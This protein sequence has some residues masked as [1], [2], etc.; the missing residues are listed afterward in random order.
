M[1][2]IKKK[3]LFIYFWLH[4]VFVTVHKLFLVAASSSYSLVAVHELLISV[5][6]VLECVGMCVCVWHMA[7]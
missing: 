4:W 6:S 7:Q 5:A 1:Q 3:H 2:F